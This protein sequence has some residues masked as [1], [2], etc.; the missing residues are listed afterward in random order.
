VIT[1]NTKK[2]KMANCFKTC[3]AQIKH[4]I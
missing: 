1:N 4:C 2:E 3:T